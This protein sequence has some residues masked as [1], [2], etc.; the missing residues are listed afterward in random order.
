[1]RTKARIPDNVRLHTWNVQ[2]LGEIARGT[3]VGSEQEES[4]EIK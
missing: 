4:Q 3:V 2:G 1:M